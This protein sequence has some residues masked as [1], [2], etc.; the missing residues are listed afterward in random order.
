MAD[1]GYKKMGEEA[2]RDDKGKKSRRQIATR[3]RGE[4]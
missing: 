3:H 4:E 1:R 2:A